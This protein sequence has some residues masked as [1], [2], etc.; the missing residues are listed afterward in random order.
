MNI[1]FILKSVSV[2]EIFRFTD[3]VISTEVASWDVIVN[4]I[5]GQPSYFGITSRVVLS[6]K[7]THTQNLIMFLALCTRSQEAWGF[8]G[9]PGLE[10]R[11]TGGSLCC[12]SSFFVGPEDS[13]AL[14]GT[15]IFSLE[16]VSVCFSFFSFQ[17]HKMTI[18]EPTESP[19]TA[20]FMFTKFKQSFR[21]IS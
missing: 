1:T 7:R 19:F 17:N 20:F 14:F 5:S 18:T 11:R 8:F 3:S 10:Y 2:R 4:V 15:F 16:F 12:S 21:M 6:H 13:S 9:V